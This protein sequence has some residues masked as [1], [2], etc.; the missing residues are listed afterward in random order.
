MS[1]LRLRTRIGSDAASRWTRR[2]PTKPVPPV[3]NNRRGIL[4]NELHKGTLYRALKAAVDVVFDV[5]GHLF[6]FV[7]AAVFRFALRS[8]HRGAATVSITRRKPSPA[9][10]TP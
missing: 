2:R 4:K 3:T 8:T 6:F 7:G 5:A 10:I 9:G 1:G